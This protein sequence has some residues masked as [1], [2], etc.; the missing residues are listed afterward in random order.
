M[1]MKPKEDTEAVDP[2]G[3]PHMQEEDESNEEVD[4]ALDTLLSGRAVEAESVPSQPEANF[5]ELDHSS[6]PSLFSEYELPAAEERETSKR[7]KYDVVDA[8]NTDGRECRGP[9]VAEIAPA[10]ISLEALRLS[11]KQVFAYPWEKG[12]LGRFFG[13]KEPLPRPDLQMQ[14][15]GQ[16]AR[17]VLLAP[18]YGFKCWSE[19]R[20]DFPVRSLSVSGS[21]LAAGGDREICVFNIASSQLVLQLPRQQEKIQGISMNSGGSLLACCFRGHVT[22]LPLESVS[23]VPDDK[24]RYKSRGTVTSLSL[25]ALAFLASPVSGHHGALGSPMDWFDE[26]FMVSSC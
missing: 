13:N 18:E 23:D 8:D 9:T 10:G 12:R 11:N 6:H 21:F 22:L 5:P 2:F 20:C 16:D 15:G 14:P 25:R 4:R 19:L 24:D 1:G 3:V 17:V 7:V 26:E